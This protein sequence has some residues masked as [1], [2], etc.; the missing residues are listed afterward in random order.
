MPALYSDGKLFGILWDKG[1]SG[2]LILSNLGALD[3]FQRWQPDDKLLIHTSD[4][5]FPETRIIAVEEIRQRYL[6]WEHEV[7][8]ISGHKILPL[9]RLARE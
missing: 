6:R 7:Y 4:R 2:Y 8:V 5:D 1:P 3:E 9:E